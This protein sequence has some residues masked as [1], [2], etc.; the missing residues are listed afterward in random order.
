MADLFSRLITDNRD[1]S[2]DLCIK[3]MNHDEIKQFNIIM[4][5]EFLKNFEQ[6]ELNLL[7]Q[8]LMY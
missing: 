1:N 2:I 6:V 4:I 5:L 3:S 8:K 7:I